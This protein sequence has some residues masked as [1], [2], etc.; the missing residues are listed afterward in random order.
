MP[1]T[2]INKNATKPTPKSL[3]SLSTSKSEEEEIEFLKEFPPLE[4]SRVVHAIEDTSWDTVIVTL[5]AINHVTKR[6]LDKTKLVCISGFSI[7]GLMVESLRKFASYHRIP[8][9]RKM[10]KNQLCSAI[11]EGKANH[12]K[13]IPEGGFNVEVTVEEQLPLSPIRFTNVLFS[14]KIRPLLSICG[15]IINKDKLTEGKK[16]N[17]DLHDAIAREYNNIENNSYGKI[18]YPEIGNFKA[19]DPPKLSFITS[20]KSSSS[21][22]ALLRD[23]EYCFNKWMLSGTHEESNDN[24]MKVVI[25]R[26]FVDFVNNQ[27][28]MIYFHK[29][30]MQYPNILANALGKLTADI[31][32]ESIH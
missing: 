6:G 1:P 4:V 8:K 21:F 19:Y 27:G 28:A 15:Q 18:V 20:K 29:C 24:I 10:N 13:G 16:T 17:S 2:P 3:S 23:Y 22:K 32:F 12:E 26:P 5:E 11:L 31:F 9:S 14:D 25:D 30:I 7:S